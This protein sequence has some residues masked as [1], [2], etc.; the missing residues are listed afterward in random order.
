MKTRTI[1]ASHLWPGMLLMDYTHL[2]RVCGI[3][4]Y[5]AQAEG[6]LKICVIWKDTE[7]SV[8]YDGCDLVEILDEFD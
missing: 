2:G 6:Y 1:K 5:D 8:T 3:A 4:G 7:Y